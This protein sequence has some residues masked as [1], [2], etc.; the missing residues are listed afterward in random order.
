MFGDMSCLISVILKEANVGSLAEGATCMAS[1][2]YN[3]NFLCGNALE[4]NTLKDW[5]T[6]GEG[7]GA[8]LEVTFRLNHIHVTY[9]LAVVLSNFTLCLCVCLRVRA[10]VR[11]RACVRACVA[12]SLMRSC[13]D[14]S[15]LKSVYLR[16]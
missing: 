11:M 14:R 10:C 6:R 1:S 4:S 15:P 5:A 8:W 9:L 13:S 7:I 3:S 2:E 16:E 12:L